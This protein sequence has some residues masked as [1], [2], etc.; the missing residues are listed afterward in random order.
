[1]PLRCTSHQT[2]ERQGDAQELRK[3]IWMGKVSTPIS[4]SVAPTSART[5]AISSTSTAATAI[6]SFKAGLRR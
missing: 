2:V 1:M 4:G 3:G 6:Q 5:T